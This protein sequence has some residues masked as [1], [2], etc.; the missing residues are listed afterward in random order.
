MPTINSEIKRILKAKDAGIKSGTQAMLGLLKELQKQILGEL[1]QAALGSWDA[2]HLKQALDA[3]EYQISNFK[4]KATAEADGLLKDSWGKGQSMVDMPLA[5]AGVYVGWHLPTSVLD[6]LKDFTF[7]RISGLSNDAWLK[8]KGELNLGILGGKTPQEVAAAIGKNLTDPSIFASIADR[9][10]VITKTE[11]GRVFS[12][13]TQLRMEQAA[14]YVDGLEKQWI[15]AGHPKKARPSHLAA[16]GQHVPVNE[17]FNIG[18]V[19]MMS[20]RE[21]GAPLEEVINCG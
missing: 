3:I 13:A 19:L 7:D 12:E 10:E 21:P 16:H 1:G 17:L 8:I 4:A 14:E 9:A 18:G 15:H 6:T 5:E 2:Y 11:M 20:P